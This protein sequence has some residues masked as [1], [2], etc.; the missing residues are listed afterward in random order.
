MRI[1]KKIKMDSIFSITTRNK[2]SQ[3]YTSNTNNKMSKYVLYQTPD[4]PLLVHSAN[5]KQYP[6]IV[7][8]VLY[9][10]DKPEYY[11]MYQITRDYYHH[12]SNVKT[13]YYTFDPSLNTEYEQKGDMLYFKG[14]ESLVPGVL[15]KTIRAFQYVVSTYPDTD[16][17]IR[18]NISTIVNL[19]YLSGIL[20]QISIEYGCSNIG[21]I[22]SEYRDVSCGIIDNRYT[23]LVFPSGTAILFSKPFLKRILENIHLI[24]NEVIDDIS[25]G[26]YINNYYPDTQTHIFS[27]YIIYLNSSNIR[28]IDFTRYLFYR[29]KNDNRL[30][31]VQHIKYIVWQL[32][33]VD[34]RKK[35]ISSYRIGDLVLVKLTPE[36]KQEILSDYPD[37]IAAEF[38]KLER[39]PMTKPQKIALLSQIVK[40]YIQI[41]NDQFPPDITQS[42]VI[43]LRLGDVMC[44]NT[45]H[46]KSKRPIELDELKNRLNGNTD[47]KY[48]IGN[49]FFAKPSSTNYLE[50]IEAS[51]TYLN[52]VLAV[53]NAIHYDSKNADIDL[54]CAVLGKTFIQGR[55]FYSQLIT[56]IRNYLLQCL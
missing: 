2:P 54:C 33:R 18:T 39:S 7:Q 17:I 14:T 37:S 45:Y 53:I 44:G 46:E 35:L 49:V 19:F 40:K 32:Q 50:C 9:S 28:Q 11:E 38:I 31:D 15:D 12:F 52:N 51:N 36:E 29:N 22:H 42:T 8:L 43:H 48:V 4:L 23:G 25:I 16:Y 5:P 47:Q 1:Q 30:N 21:K 24:Q 56:E 20:S 55:G 10:N 3:S 34:L 27:D 26:S 13:L 41:Y 6:Q